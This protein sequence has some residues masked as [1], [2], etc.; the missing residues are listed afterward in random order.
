MVIKDIRGITPNISV[1]DIGIVVLEIENRGEFASNMIV[2]IGFLHESQ[3]L[4]W[5]LLIHSRVVQ[6]WENWTFRQ[7]WNYSVEGEWR[8]PVTILETGIHDVNQSNNFKEISIN[9][10]EN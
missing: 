5:H 1:G 3:Q 10:T 9:V 4:P 7:A 6:P 8:H 2:D